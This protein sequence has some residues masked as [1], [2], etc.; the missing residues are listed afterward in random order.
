MVLL[1]RLTSACRLALRKHKSDSNMNVN[2][3]IVYNPSFLSWPDKQD[4]QILQCHAATQQYLLIRV[5]HFRFCIYLCHLPSIPVHWRFYLGL[6]YWQ[7]E[8]RPTSSAHSAVSFCIDCASKPDL[9]SHANCQLWDKLHS[10]L[11]RREMLAPSGHN[12]NS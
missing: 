5:K 9:T 3:N 6:P 11:E 8:F 2:V 7:P 1:P 10:V 12:R 4:T